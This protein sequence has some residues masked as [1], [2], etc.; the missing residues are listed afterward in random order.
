MADKKPERYQYREDAVLIEEVATGRKHGLLIS[1]FNE[2]GR[3]EIFKDEYPK[4]P[5]NDSPMGLV[6][7][8]DDFSKAIDEANNIKGVFA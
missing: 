4:Y 5:E 2:E 3:F 7:D 8:E 1:N 6:W